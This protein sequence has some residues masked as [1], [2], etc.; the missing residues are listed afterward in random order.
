M[1]FQHIDSRQCNAAG[2]QRIYS[3]NH[4]RGT[5]AWRISDRY[6]IEFW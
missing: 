5:N 2:G 3:D 1:I 6:M 4:V